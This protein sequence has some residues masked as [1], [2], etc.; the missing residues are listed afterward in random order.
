MSALAA[1]QE[2]LI[3]KRKRMAD[4]FTEAGDNMDFSQ[5]KSIEGDTSRKVEVIRQWNTELDTLTD[6]VKSLVEID[7]IRMKNAEAFADLTKPNGGVPMPAKD[8]RSDPE[9]LRP[10][11]P[12][13]FKSIGQLFIDSDGFKN[14][15]RSMKKGPVIELDSKGL[16]G[17]L[18]NLSPDMENGAYSAKTLMQ[19]SSYP[20][21]ERDIGLTLLTATRRPVVADLI[22]TGSTDASSI[23]YVEETTMTN[24]AAAVAEGGTKPESALAYTERTAI[25][26]KIATFI[27]VTDELM[28]DA[29]ALRSTIDARL[30]LFV[31]LEEERE[32]LA[33]SGAPEL[34]GITNWAGIQ[35]QAKGADPVPDAIYKAMTKIMVNAFMDPTGIVMHPNDWQDIRLLRT[36]DGIYI[37]GSPADPGV[38]RVWG[39]PVVAT[40]AQTENTAIVAAF[41]GASQIFRRSGI[42][43]VASSEHSDFFVKNQLAIRA[44]ERLIFVIYRPLAFCTVTGI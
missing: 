10:A 36:A 8:T 12:N 14:Y 16:W 31:T 28:A 38:A 19:L 23:R 2:E 7:K 35:T 39:L 40:V 44:E 30:R 34:T 27:P 42:E 17:G 4:V 37:W 18:P 33:G 13:Q 9:G 26:R 1:K 32:L 3:A 41:D 25:A 11:H 21:Q 20:I 15:S 29:P 6:E 24:A 43:V 5:V 22:P